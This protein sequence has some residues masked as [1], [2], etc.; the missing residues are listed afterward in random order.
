MSDII[1]VIG[2]FVTQRFVKTHDR[3]EDWKRF[4]QC[5]EVLTPQYVSYHQITPTHHGDDTKLTISVLIMDPHY[6]SHDKLDI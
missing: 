3:A 6:G 5:E 1:H 4:K 2:Y